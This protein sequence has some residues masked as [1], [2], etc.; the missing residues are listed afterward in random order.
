M[1]S[2]GPGASAFSDRNGTADADDAFFDGGINVVD[3]E[4][5]VYGA[6]LDGF[7]GHAEDDGGGFVLSDDEAAGG[8]DGFATVGAVIAHAGEDCADAERSGVGSDGFH[9]DVDVGEIAVEA[10]GCA[11]ELDAAGR[12]DAKMLS[13]G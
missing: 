8:F 6:G 4:N 10:A 12:R 13:A 1:V 2:R 9:G 7:G 3:A 5:V 11:I